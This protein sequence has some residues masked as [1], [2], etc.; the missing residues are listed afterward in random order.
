[1]AAFAINNIYH[2]SIK[3]TPFMLVKG[4][5]PRMPTALNQ[6]T[7]TVTRGKSQL[8]TQFAEELQKAVEVAKQAITAAQNRQKAYADLSR[9]EVDFPVGAQV[10]LSTK[11]LR[12]RN[13]EREIARMKLLPKYIGPYTI[14]EK[15]G[16]VAYKLD[17]P[18][19]TKI[20]PVFHVSLLKP[21]NDPDVV[22]ASKPLPAP[23]DWL[24]GIPT[25]E[26]NK[27]L[28][29]KEVLSGRKRSVAYLVSWKGFDEEHD[30][31]EPYANLK[32]DIPELVAAYD[33][34]HTITHTIPRVAKPQPAAKGKSK[35]D[36]L[37]KQLSSPPTPQT[38]SEVT[39]AT[40]IPLSLPPVPLP[41]APTRG[42]KQ[43]TPKQPVRKSTRIQAAKAA[44][45]PTLN[46]IQ[47]AVIC[48][49]MLTYY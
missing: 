15:V 22:H 28:N 4:Y 6:L 37:H 47:D 19:S 35:P 10:L 9:R 34:Q 16:P 48:T 25:F 27:I 2:E 45:P 46:M 29:H 14:L 39:D 26:V 33:A 11:N 8:A 1:M 41:L 44:K 23:L 20:H 12:L 17:L 49:Y 3:T 7:D 36:A 32:I 13:D 24:D 40:T 42:K 43:A 21:Y 38:P 31:W 5:H 18:T 30:S